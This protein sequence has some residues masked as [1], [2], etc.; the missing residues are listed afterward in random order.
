MQFQALMHAIFLDWNSLSSPVYLV[1]SFKTAQTSPAGK[2]FHD[3]PR[4][5]PLLH[6]GCSHCSMH[7]SPYHT[8]DVYLWTVHVLSTSVSQTSCP[9]MFLQHGPSTGHDVGSGESTKIR[10]PERWDD[11]KQ[12]WVVVWLLQP[13][14]RQALRC[15][16][17][18]ERE[19][20]YKNRM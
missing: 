14:W 3:F 6:L 15:T 16:V 20:H 9:V 4:Q 19:K 12:V 11:P 1:K 10:G 8:W 18:A 5:S 17:R 13:N 2:A 7:H